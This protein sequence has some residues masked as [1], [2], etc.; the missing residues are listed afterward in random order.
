MSEHLVLVGAGGHAS[1]VLGVVE[2]LNAG[3]PRWTVIGCLDDGEP[4]VFRFDGRDLVVLG[5]V[6]SIDELDAAWVAA[7]GFPASRRGCVDR[8]EPLASREP[9]TLV[10]PLADVGAR[11][12]LEPGVVV[13]GQ[14]RLSPRAHLRQHASVAY[15]ASVGHDSVVGSCSAVMPGAV[16]AGDVHI[17]SDVLIGAGAVVLEGR[18]IGDGATIGAGAVVTRDVAPGATV[19]GVPAAPS[20]GKS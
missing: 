8:V 17:G 14:A 20:S 11:V 19:V 18:N 4:E 13:L 15:H 7:V 6:A 10:H 2:A 9:A 5:S 1:D 3:S 16:V 12:G